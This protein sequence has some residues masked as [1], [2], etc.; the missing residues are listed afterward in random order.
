MAVAGQRIVAQRCQQVVGRHP[1]PHIGPF[2]HRVLQGVQEPDRRG[3]VGT[4][5]VEHQIALVEG[6]HHQLEV[7]LFQVPQSSVEQFRRAA[8]STGGVVPLLDE[9]YR[10]ASRGCVEGGTCSGDSRSDHNHIE[11]LRLHAL[12][13]VCPLFGA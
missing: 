5:Q 6:F 10:Q 2:P 13:I 8:G 3:K 4:E 11:R 7:E 9:R 12:K 1:G